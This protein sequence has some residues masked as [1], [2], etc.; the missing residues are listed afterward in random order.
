MPDM[1]KGEIDL[2]LHG[3]EGL[4]YPMPDS[5]IVQGGEELK[6]I[7]P[8]KNKKVACVAEKAVSCDE[9]ANIAE[10]YTQMCRKQLL[11]NLLGHSNSMRIA[12]M[13]FWDGDGPKPRGREAPL[14]VFCTSSKCHHGTA[15][16][17]SFQFVATV[18]LQHVWMDC[19]V[20]MGLSIDGYR[21]YL[22]IFEGYSGKFFVYLLRTKAEASGYA[23]DWLRKAHT[24]THIE[25]STCT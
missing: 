24:N 13:M 8:A 1:S 14:C 4:F 7:I 5:C 12:L 6:P 2:E 21:H 15:N 11:H 3:R 23:L 19:S 16:K 9:E 22:M 10:R 25:P 18:V 17:I 20:N